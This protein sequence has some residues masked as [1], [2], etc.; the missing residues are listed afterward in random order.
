MALG[1][2][3][4]RARSFFLSGRRRV[5]ISSI[6]MPFPHTVRPPDSGMESDMF[7]KKLS[8]YLLVALL[9]TAAFVSLS[10]I[11]G[12][13]RGTADS[14][15][16][17]WVSSNAPDPTVTFNWA[18]ISAS[19]ADVGFYY[20]DDDYGGPFA[21]G[22]DFEFYGNTYSEFY[23]STNGLVSLGAPTYSAY[24]DPI[25][26]TWTPNNFVA[27]FWDDLCADYWPYNTGSVYY[28]TI[29]AS[30]D[31]QLVVQWHE[32]SLYGDYD[33][34]TF[35]AIL[36][37][38][39]EIW[40]QYLTM[41]GVAG[42]G[43]TIGIENL[44]GTDGSQY[45]YDTASV[46]DGLAVRFHVGLLGFGPDSSET[47]T[48]GSVATH[49][50]IVTNNQAFDDT[51]D[52]TYTS[53]EGWIVELLDAYDFPLADTDF[54]GEVDTG[55]VA[56]G[57]FVLIRAL[58]TVPWYPSELVETT[59]L[60]ASS[61]AAPSLYDFA[62]LTTSVSRASLTPFHS[63]WAYDSDSDGDYD[64]LRV[65]VSVNAA[66]DG[67]GH[68][69]CYLYDS[70]GEYITWTSWYGDLY[71]GDTNC[72]VSFSGSDIFRDAADGEFDV[73]IYLY[74]EGWY[75]LEDAWHTTGSY[76]ASEF[77]PPP[78]MF[79][80]PHS[81]YA[82]DDD[83]DGLYEVLVVD[84]SIE[85]FDEGEYYVYA[86]LRD[87]IFESAL[88]YA[89][90]YAY[91]SPGSN[92]LELIFPAGPM[93]E[94]GW[95]IPYLVEMDLYLD[96]YEFLEDAE[97]TT[98]TYLWSEFEPLPVLFAP[99]YSEDGVDLDLDGYYDHLAIT[100][101]IECVE[102]GEYR[103]EVEL[104]AW[105]WAEN[106][107]FTEVLELDAGTFTDYVVTVDHEVFRR[108]SFSGYVG[109]EMYLWNTSSPVMYQYDS[110]STGYH[111]LYE[112]DPIGAVFDWTEDEGRDTDLNGYYDQVVVTAYIDPLDTGYFE[113]EV[114]VDDPW[115]D[116]FH[117]SE[118]VVH[119]EEGVQFVYE[120]V[121][122]AEEMR[123]AGTDGWW[124]VYIDI[125]DESDGY[126]YDSTTH[127]MYYS[128]YE[129]E[130]IGAYFSPPHDEYG[131]DDDANGL[132]ESLVF[133]I[134]IMA[135]TT[136]FYDLEVEILD[137][138][139]NV[140]D[141]F[142]MTV[143]LEEDTVTAVPIELDA[144]VF[145]DLWA[146]GY[147]RLNMDLYDHVTGMY[148]DSDYYDSGYHYPDEFEQ[149]PVMFDPPHDDYGIDTDDD[150]L[151]DYL[152][153]E[154]ELDCDAPGS[155]TV[156][157]A[158]H[159]PW[160][161]EIATASKT[162][163]FTIANNMVEFLFDGWV[164]W[165]NGVSGY[166]EVELWVEDSHGR[167][168][169]TDW[170]YC[171]YYSMWY[172]ELPPAQFSYPHADR[173]VDLDDDGLYDFLVVTAAVEASG[174]GEYVVAGALYD[175]AYD[176]VAFALNGTV[177][178]EG[179]N[180]V[181]L[182][183]DG[184]LVS[185]AGNDP[186]YVDLYLMDPD[187][188]EMDYDYHY[189]DAWYLPS[190][191]N[192]T[193]PSLESGWAY[194]P[195]TVDGLVDEGEWEGAAAVDLVA[196]DGLNMVDA[197]VY[198]M[199]D[200]SFVYFLVD[201]PG[202]QTMTDG[203][204][205][206]VAF[207]TGNDGVFT[208]GYEDWFAVEAI[209][210]LSVTTHMV[211]DSIDD[212]VAHCAPF[213]EGLEDHDGLSAAAGFGAT[214]LS[215]S[216]H[217]VYEFAVPLALL[218]LAPGDTVGFA[219]L[220]M[221]MDA[222]EY[223]YS[224]WP[225]YFDSYPRPELYGD[226]VLSQERPLTV[227]ELSG[228]E[229]LEGWFL[230]DVEVTL[231]ATGGTGGVAATYYKVGGG[232][233]EEYSE[234]FTVSG[235]ALHVLM[236]YSS[237]VSG[238]DEFVRSISIGVDTES[239]V[240]SAQ[241]QGTQ[242]LVE[243]FVSSV[244]VVFTAGDDTSGVG[245]VMYS[246]DEGEWAALT[247]NSLTVSADGFHTVEFYCVDVAGNE[248]TVK[249]VSFKIDTTPPETTCIVDRSTV[250][251]SSADD[252]SGVAATMYRIDGGAWQAYT[253]AFVVEGSGNHTVEYYSVDIAGNQEDVRTLEVEGSSGAG[254]FNLEMWMVL[255]I[256]ALIILISLGAIFGMRRKAKD[257]DTKAIIKDI[258]SPMA[259]LKD[260]TYEPKPPKNLLHPEEEI[261]PPPPGN[262]K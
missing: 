124:D 172:F 37:E 10:S 96:D 56:A 123:A 193:V 184:W 255:M 262:G 98:A 150:T 182:W 142:V 177:L 27:P 95:D 19:G 157:A 185:A 167:L 5:F 72:T 107:L 166:F 133:D 140:Y 179:A 232:D 31:M 36:N 249:S 207:E 215:G 155:Y 138:Y 231:T 234:T 8:A 42:E 15:G 60:N 144:Y 168:L 121:L 22:F 131:V 152:M 196:A 216:A 139:W 51:F 34:M 203:D 80:S 178:V 17:T 45:S 162:Q 148:Y 129:F 39:G 114:V 71:T 116:L 122:D 104:F 48:Q 227:A 154:V 53:D 30:P 209:G 55:V 58:V 91:M 183:F 211:Y 206:A 85:V 181:E 260:D 110:M 86:V 65:D 176:E 92:S 145:W 199:N 113:I 175:T 254:A 189:L 69:D 201:A 210:E 202:D 187:W 194:Q 141:E 237:D 20:G 190:E 226:L 76:V 225:V 219:G 160:G 261:P 100:I 101:P 7:A 192:A 213:D 151:Y 236:Y 54:S 50:L 163:T 238:N 228:D 256:T 79:S 47:V 247:G 186:Y 259:Q 127:Y 33:L 112:F 242:G 198:V 130:P 118:E 63:D 233:W 68:L 165:A 70:I 230:S 64:Y 11:A 156:Y 251:L 46:S 67:P 25:P 245:A 52:I 220:P 59:V 103:V 224:T 77:D 214:P 24:N 229:G 49:E 88:A 241:E 43:A 204:Y 126:W 197:T 161:S 61:A 191:F 66:A 205:A 195:P 28:E 21:I 89:W 94:F 3:L 108:S 4:R 174:A 159:D 32:V 212:W 250:S 153:V 83:S 102:S 23:V 35:Q 97:H 180:M 93:R 169:D 243:W 149:P 170:H 158:L 13:D 253:V 258:G 208:D 57:S 90:N 44:G 105:S 164:I 188:V 84:A 128:I 62:T 82:F 132:F 38:T 12:A 146:Y 1:V 41:S 78:A 6:W 221:V 137:P 117:Y 248:E 99:P 217:R 135:Y 239:P 222:V 40:F 73:H 16:Y 125:Y 173:A 26:S 75:F 111:D 74:D 119:M 240:S 200:D 81:D 244:N 147:W 134:Y 14:F 115:D 235:D 257:S 171:D 246:L 9:S 143:H 87:S 18:D 223:D 106:I 2:F 136:G 109:A 218:G 252:T 120:V 29:G